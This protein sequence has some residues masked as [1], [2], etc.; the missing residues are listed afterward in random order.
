MGDDTQL[1]VLNLNAAALKPLIEEIV[2]ATVARLESDRSQLDGR[3]AYTE[4]EAA[5]LLGLAQHQLRD[6]RLRERI[7]A[8]MGPGRKILYAKRDLLDYLASRRWEKRER[9]GS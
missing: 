4:P 6:E 5:G 1:A 3:L 2:A 7:R 9:P 8:S